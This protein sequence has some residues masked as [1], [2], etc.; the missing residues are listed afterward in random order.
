MS[1]LS[2]LRIFRFTGMM[3]R[4]LFTIFFFNELSCFSFCCI[5]DPSRI[6]THIGNQTNCAL[7]PKSDPFI[8]LLCYHHGFSSTEV[9]LTSRF[10]LHITRGK[11]QCRISF[12]FLFLNFSH[13]KVLAVNSSCN[14]LHCFGI[15][16]FFLL[17]ID[18]P[19]IRFELLG[20]LLEV[21]INAPVFFWHKITNFLFTINNH[22]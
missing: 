12:A 18:T 7:F 19:E 21:S 2:P 6:C 17:A 15:W 9:Q 13:F 8:Q 5:R 14:F 3:L 22:F 20:F 11:W 1:V 16:Q 10:L 4:I